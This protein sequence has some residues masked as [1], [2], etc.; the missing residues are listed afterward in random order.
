MTLYLVRWRR[1]S[2]KLTLNVV[3]LGGDGG[4]CGTH[5]CPA[6][7]SRFLSCVSVP[8]FCPTFL[9]RVSVPYFC[10]AFLSR[11]SVQLEVAVVTWLW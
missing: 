10:P 2:Q 7:L 9:S 1:H 6:F 8:R 5:F 3:R 11:V 4:G